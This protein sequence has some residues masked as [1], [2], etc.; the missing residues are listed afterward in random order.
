MN[1]WEPIA[2]YLQRTFMQ[3]KILLKQFIIKDDKLVV[4]PGDK[5]SCVVITQRDDYD[6]KLQNIIDDGIRKGIYSPTIDTTL[7]D[8]KKFQDFLCRSFKGK[9]DR[10]VDMRPVSNQPCKTYA[11][12]KTR[13]FGSLEDITIQ[14][15]KFRPIISQIGTS[16]RTLQR[17]CQTI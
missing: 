14:N 4:L 8:L 9:Y 15:L 5:D 13:K 2:T 7:S 12:A 1:F 3:Q 17:Y 11:T 16:L 6:M 10:Y